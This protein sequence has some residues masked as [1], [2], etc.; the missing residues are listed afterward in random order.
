MRSAALPVLLVVKS[1]QGAVS[2]LR[3]RERNER[4]TYTDTRHSSYRSQG[5]RVQRYKPMVSI[6][7]TSSD[8]KVN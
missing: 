4:W 2:P 5:E 8:S 7:R 3:S 1:F 6:C